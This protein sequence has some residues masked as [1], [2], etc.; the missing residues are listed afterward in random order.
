MLHS[1]ASNGFVSPVPATSRYRI[2]CR[3][4]DGSVGLVR[5][6]GRLGDACRLAKSSV[7]R[8]LVKLRTDRSSMLL[9]SQRA[10]EVYIEQWVGTLVDGKWEMLDRSAGGYRFEF[11]D[12]PLRSSKRADHRW[13]N[14]KSRSQGSLSDETVSPGRDLRAGDIVECVLLERRTRKNGWFARLAAKP[15][16][17][18][19]TGT[20]PT[21]SDFQ[22][23]Q[24]VHLKLCG[25][26]LETGFAQ[27]AWVV[28]PKT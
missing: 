12:T 15:A 11:F 1:N 10:R 25:L 9:D 19:V 18:P 7:D 23:G 28:Q 22:A 13:G 20:A 17:G 27:F 5:L 3:H 21:S 26:K 8:H 24:S 16:S 14:T 4:A 2:M 6:C